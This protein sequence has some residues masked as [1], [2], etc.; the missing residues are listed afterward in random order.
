MTPENAAL[1][2]SVRDGSPRFRTEL[3]F[4]DGSRQD[5]SGVLYRQVESAS[6]GRVSFTGSF[7]ELLDIG[8]VKSIL[9]DG[10]EFR[11]SDGEAPAPRGNWAEGMTPLEYLRSRTFGEHTPVYPALRDDS[12]RVS[13]ALEGVWTDGWTTELLLEITAERRMEVLSLVQEGG[14]I[15]F[16]ARDKKG[17]AVA[18]GALSNNMAD[19]L[20]GL[21]VECAEKAAE[22]TIGDGDAALTIPLD[23][24]KLA[25]LPQVEPREG[26]PLPTEAPGA[27]E[28]SRRA[29]AEKL[30]EGVT[31]AEVSITGE[32]GCYEIA[33][34]RLWFSGGCFRALVL[35]RRLDGE[36]Y[37]LLTLNESLSEFQVRLLSDGA[38][39]RL[40]EGVDVR[41]RTD[42]PER[43]LG[44]RIDYRPED[45]PAADGLRLI[46]TPPEGGRI[47]LDL[48][49]TE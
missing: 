23:M 27:M 45:A 13:L 14:W 42:G 47:T 11:L 15:T 12:D 26:T 16:D 25:R 7:P 39:L 43:C 10:V 22:L 5:I 46:W 19:G 34:T 37:P 3:L 32:N 31:P 33:V 41:G 18:V 28:Q 2:E 40:S 49:M 9:F 20:L 38:E 35:Q 4:R 1:P 24:K 6:T 29:L 30:F 44:L 17:N 36:D 21:V 8:R 48:P